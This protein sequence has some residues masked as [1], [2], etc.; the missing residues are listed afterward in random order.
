MAKYKFTNKAVDDLTQIWN[1]TVKKW[2]E[3]QA[4]RY[5]D[6]LIENCKDIASDPEI[7][8][9]YSGITENLSGFRAGRHIIFYRRIKEDEVEITRILHE[10]MDLKIKIEEK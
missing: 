8:K 6:M 4:N 10:K 1:Y 7:G 5:Y 2:S 9:K 3:N